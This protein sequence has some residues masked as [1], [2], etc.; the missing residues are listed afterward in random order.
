[1][2]YRARMA[3][4]YLVEGIFNSYPVGGVLES[5]AATNTTATA[6]HYCGLSLDMVWGLLD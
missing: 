1:M 3:Y 2:D 4:P 5:I 6:D